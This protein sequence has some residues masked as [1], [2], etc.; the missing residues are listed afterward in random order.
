MVPKEYYLIIIGLV[1]SAYIT[2]FYD[3]FKHIFENYSQHVTPILDSTILIDVMA[4]VLAMGIGIGVV[5]ALRR[6]KNKQT[7]NSNPES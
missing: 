7:S 3:I 2:I 4:G 1:A 5:F 6:K